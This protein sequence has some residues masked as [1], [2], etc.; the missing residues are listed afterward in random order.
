MSGILIG[1]RLYSALFKKNM[2]GDRTFRRHV[3]MTGCCLN[4]RALCCLCGVGD[5]T[6]TSVPVGLLN[7]LQEGPSQSRCL[8]VLIFGDVD[9]RT[10]AVVSGRRC[11]PF[12]R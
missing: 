11:L 3:F 4:G 7:L 12:I 6:W 5:E 2:A 9:G 1:R 10:Q 8:G